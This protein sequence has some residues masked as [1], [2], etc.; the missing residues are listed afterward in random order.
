MPVRDAGSGTQLVERD[1]EL[2]TIRAVQ[3]RAAAGA[4]SLIVIEGP[5]GIG[6]SRLLAEACA[7]AEADGLQVLRARGGLLERDL[8]YGAVRMLLERSL[9]ALDTPQREDVLSGAA[10]LAAPALSAAG[11][12]QQATADRGFAVIH[13]LF[14]CVANLAERRPLLLLLDDAH[15]FDAA[16]LRFALYLARRVS[17]LPVALVVATREDEPGPESAGSAR[18]ARP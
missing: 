17:D 10:A 6:K 15:W 18:R 14:W 7:F 8:A 2:G 9:A 13:G 4:G 12:D 3:G 11:G 5:A 1:A 16:S